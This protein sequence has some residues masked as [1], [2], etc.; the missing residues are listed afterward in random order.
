[1]RVAEI[2]NDFRNCQYHISS[3]QANPPPEEYYLEG[4]ALLR[5]CMAEA[6][7]LLNLDYNHSPQ[8]PEGDAET[9]KAL[10]KLYVA[11]IPLST[12]AMVTRAVRSTA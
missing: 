6:H 7:A 9:E 10:L 1:M 12:S 5:Q 3:L 2:V 11:H 4:Y 8:N